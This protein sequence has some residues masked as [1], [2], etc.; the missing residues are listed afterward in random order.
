M[1]GIA[2]MPIACLAAAG[3]AMAV[4]GCFGG[5][6]V[7]KQTVGTLVGAAGGAVAGSQVGK[8]SGRVAATA[9]GTLLGAFIGSEV[10][11]S[12]DRADALYAERAKN[13][14][15]ERNPT[16]ATTA[17]VNP[18]SGNQGTVTPTRTVHSDEGVPCREYRTTVTVGGDAVEAYGTACRNPDG[19]WRIVN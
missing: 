6:Q 7:N 12:L 15:L 19:T 8:G 1:V 4:A 10:G 14:A 5:M 18:D 9:V 11:K 2:R 3:L 17:W 13:A 16:G